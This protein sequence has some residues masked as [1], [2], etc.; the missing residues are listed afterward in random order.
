MCFVIS[1]T[2]LFLQDSVLEFLR[3]FAIGFTSGVMG[4]CINI[5]FDV[6]KSRIQGPQPTPGVVKYSSTIGAIKLVY[7][8]EG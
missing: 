4:S 3:K 6:A 2:L 7:Q 5:P 8:E 1:F